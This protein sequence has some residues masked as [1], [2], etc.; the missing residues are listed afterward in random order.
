VADI[1]DVV[2]VGGGLAG[3]KTAEA[4]RERGF[5]GRVTIVGAELHRPYERPPL[6]KGLLL[7]KEQRESVFVHDED[8]YAQNNVELRLG[9]TALAVDRTAHEVQIDDGTAVP[10]DRLV[11]A[12]GS[13]P[14][15]LPIPGADAQ[16][17]HV[18]RTLD[19]SETLTGLFGTA[20]RL[21]VIGAGWIGL[22]VTAAARTA[23]L[24]VVIVESMSLPL[25]RVLGPEAA[26]VFA[27]LHADHGVELHFDA[28]IEEI[29]TSGGVASGVRLA[30][31]TLID[32]DAV[33][34]GVGAAPNTH[35]A[36]AAGLKVDDGVLTD[37]SLR[38]DDP[39]ILA[40]GDIA[41]AEHPVL[42]RRIRVEHWANALNQPAVAAAA[43][44]GENAVYDRLPYFFTD[45]YDL[46]M[47][48]VGYAEP[49]DYDAVVFRGDTA[50]REFVAFWLKD[51]RVL[52]G[53][54]VNV[55]DVGDAVKS[56]IA[57]GRPVDAARLR[58]P[59]VPLTEV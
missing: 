53:M 29:T 41:R 15:R 43:L 51:S 42:G 54:N 57:D 37:A 55:W 23:G 5:D 34:L 56:L 24:S 11:L 18:L 16:G 39:H 27:G 21:L 4:L 36:E 35:L 25:L 49:G 3:A 6:S 38:T 2:I 50:A 9:T 31:G 13:S 28:S 14:R 32:A 10:Y 22:E 44:L 20:Q 19:D 12:T 26:A 40:V 45:Q 46:G 1:Q 8:W 17:V 52:A 48:Y 7:G 47:E 58:D 33:L 30:D 59:S